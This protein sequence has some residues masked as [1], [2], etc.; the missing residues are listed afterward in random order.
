MSSQRRSGFRTLDELRTQMQT[1]LER[2]YQHVAYV[3]EKRAY[4]DILAS[5]HT[6]AL[7]QGVVD[8]GVRDD[9]ATNS[10]PP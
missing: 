6:F 4:L 2:E 9:L 10:G 5:G 3:R 1:S 8:V 7:P